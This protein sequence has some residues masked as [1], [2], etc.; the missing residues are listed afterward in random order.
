M[1]T[2]NIVEPRDMRIFSEPLDL[3]VGSNGMP[4]ERWQALGGIA[5][6]GRIF[7]CPLDRIFGR[8]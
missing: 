1:E 5:T 7:L 6:S 3:H 8:H 4:A 2:D